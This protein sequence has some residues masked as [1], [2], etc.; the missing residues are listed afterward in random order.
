VARPGTGERRRG[1][2]HT[3]RI[4]YVR[5]ADQYRLDEVTDDGVV[6]T[7][8]VEAVSD[9]AFAEYLAA[10]VANFRQLDVSS[11]AIDDEVGLR[12]RPAEA[13]GMSTRPS[14]GPVRL[15]PGTPVTVVSDGRTHA[16]VVQPYEPE[17]TLTHTFPVR[18]TETG[19]WRL[20][21]ARDVTVVQPEESA[22]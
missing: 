21:T 20:L 22:R 17:N 8:L 13:R 4:T 9:E 5:L 14:P 10:L 19:Q 6:H 18:F 15:T 3:I 16:G 7:E 11:G 1:G 2:P 12:W